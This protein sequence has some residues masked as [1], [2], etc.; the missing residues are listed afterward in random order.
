MCGALAELV[1]VACVEPRHPT[2]DLPCGELAGDPVAL[3]DPHERPADRRVLV[4][5]E[6][7]GEERD[8]GARLGDRR[9]LTIAE[10]LGEPDAREGREEPVLGDTGDLLHRAPRERPRGSYG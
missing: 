2:A 10:P 6:T 1:D 9:G 5:D 4:F 3:V 8:G 7:G